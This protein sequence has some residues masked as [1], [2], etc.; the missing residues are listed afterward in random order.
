[1]CVKIN[2]SATVENRTQIFPCQILSSVIISSEIL[3][4]PVKDAPNVYVQTP[5]MCN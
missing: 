1:M 2:M 4:F 3:R 5:F